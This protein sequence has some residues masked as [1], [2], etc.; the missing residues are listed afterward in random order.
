MMINTKI[1]IETARVHSDF[2]RQL[3]QSTGKP[4]LKFPNC[5]LSNEKF[6]RMIAKKQYFVLPYVL[7]EHMSAVDELLA[8]IQWCSDTF[9]GHFGVKYTVR[10][11]FPSDNV[12]IAFANEEDQ[13]SFLLRSDFGVHEGW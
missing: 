11:S 8:E 10:H 5:K 12:V 4:L 3:H 13:L 1:T 6:V 2:L 9:K 7:F